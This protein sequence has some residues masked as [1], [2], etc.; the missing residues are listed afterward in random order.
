MNSFTPPKRTVLRRAVAL[1]AVG[2]LGVL[3]L[4]LQPVPEALLAQ[5]P[6]LAE[7]PTWMLKGLT[8]LNP[9]V[10]L[11]VAALLGVLVA[12][13]VGLR[14]VLAGTAQPKERANG[15]WLAAGVGLATGA[16][17]ACMDLAVAP[18]LGEPWQHFLSQASRPNAKALLLGVLYGGITEEIVMR[19]GLMSVL[20]WSL[21]IVSRRQ[22]IGGCFVV[23]A[24][25]TA[26]VFGAAHLP[27]LQA[28]MDL[29]FGIALRTLCLNGF[30]SLV[31][32]WI[33]WR[34]H[35]EAAMLS[36]ACSHLA[37]GAVWALMSLRS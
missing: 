13:R 18:C 36:H 11:I 5:R 34:Y 4:L 1:V 31:Y 32:A 7:M 23:A 15:W 2:L 28:Q 6:E 25:V 19:W 30:A 20:T 24:L 9:M 35:L 10:L 27:V 17:L 37:M 12:H 22:R 3:A 21:W 29:S 26:L 14:S 8:L 16:L 33:F